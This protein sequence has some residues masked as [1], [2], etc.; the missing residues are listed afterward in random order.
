MTWIGTTALENEMKSLQ[1]TILTEMSPDD[2]EYSK[3][4]E[5]ATP[6]RLLLAITCNGMYKARGVKQGFK[7]GPDFNYHAHVAKFNSIR[8]FTFRVGRGTR[9]IAI[10]DVSTAFLQADKCPEG[11]VK[12]TT[13]KDPLTRK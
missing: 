2:P 8:M 7:D 6:G 3:A 11:T 9:R 12:Y 4:L 5:L 10:K 1:A 13:F